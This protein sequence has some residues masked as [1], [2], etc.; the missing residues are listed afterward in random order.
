MK[1]VLGDDVLLMRRGRYLIQY[2]LL[3]PS[4]NK[5]RIAKYIFELSASISSLD[6]ENDKFSP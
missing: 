6:Y 3:P 1:A 4:P 2:I 5:G